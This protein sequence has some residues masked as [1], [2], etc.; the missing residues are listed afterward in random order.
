MHVT[1]VVVSHDGGNYLPRTLAA[2]SD[3]MRSADA[4]IGVDTGSTDNSLDLLREALGQSNVTTFHQAKSG[5][6][7]AVRAGL[8][9]LAPSGS[10]DGDGQGQAVEWI[11]LLHD[12]AAPAPDAL[13]ELLHAVERAPSVTVAGCKQL[14]WDNERHLVDA[15]LSTSRWAERL[16]LIDADEVD[17]GQYDARSDTFAVNSAGML[18]RRDVWEQLDGFDPAL[19]GSGDD[20]DFCWRNWLAGNRVVVVPTARMFHVEHRP[21]GLGT[22]S[23]ARKAQIHLRL[24]HTPWW[25]VPFQALGAL[26]GAIVRL[27]LSIL[28]KEPGYG[29]S[30]F[31]ATL[32]A[33]VRPLAVARGRR[34]AARTRRV[35]RSVVR[36]LQTPTREVRA[37][38]RSLLE[39]I[40][41]ADDPQP[42]SDL[43]APEPS[44]DA[45]DDFAALATNERGWVGTGAV[46]AACVALAAALIG[47]LGLLRSGVVTGGGLLPLPASP[48]EI[49]ASASSWWISLGAGL[50]GHGDPFAYVLWLI[51]LFGGGDG[52]AA[53]SWLLIL[54]M[55]LSAVGAWFA[56]GA[57][58]TKRRFRT[59]AALAWA[60]A[61]TLL[62]SINEGRV[63]AL[64]AHVMMPLLL[65]ALVR[66]SGSAISQPTS[67]QIKA[68]QAT[69]GRNRASGASRLPAPFRGKPGINGTPSWTA[70]AAAGLAMAVVTASAPSLLGPIIVA[71]VLAAVI[72]GQRGKTMWWS[73]LPTLALFLPYGISVLERPRSL[74]ADPGVPLGF[75]AAPLWQQLLGQPLAFGIDGGLTGLSLFGSGPVPWALILAL[76]IGVPVLLLAV[77]SLFLRGHR[78]ALARVFWLA[79]LATLASAWLVGH[80]ATGV[81]NNVIVGPFTGPA[82]S[83]SGMLL[84]GAALLGA[85]KIFAPSRRASDPARRKL[86]L[87]R[88]ASAVVV[89]L[90]VAGP[91]AGMGVWA[92]Q[93][94]LQPSTSTGSP[95]APSAEQ[96]QNSSLG[97]HR[98]IGPMD[99]GTLP[100]TAVDRGQGPERTRTLVIT[101]GEQGAFTSSL[102]RGAG[103]TLDSLS[104]IASARNI[105]GAPG[106]EE[107]ANDDAA[108]ASLRRAVAT[109][110]ASTGVDPRPDLEQLGAGFV[111]LKAADNAAQL[112]ASRIDAVPGLVAVGQTDAGWLWRVTPRDQPAASAA[113]TAHRVR[114]I[115]GQGATVGTLPSDDV[116][117]N[118]TVPSGDEGRKVVMAERSDPGWT[119]WV[120]GKQLKATTS[121]WSQAFDLPADGGELEIRYA[122]PWAVW[123]GIL[124]VVVISLTVLLAIPMPARRSRTGMS[125]DEV[126][127]RKEY[128]SV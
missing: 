38:R 64:V 123:L 32:A 92:A 62:I 69:T 35:H 27:V 79:A 24:K 1:A 23:A 6:G 41:P 50:P 91:L 34:A 8:H 59:V 2:L 121:G 30:Q 112:T 46:A 86:P 114:I 52:N 57:L 26:F 4:A 118:T 115:N 49:W 33:L 107:I 97:A 122:N 55:P 113:E 7:A 53:M 90:L 116:E 103:T 82:V 127:L 20:V 10:A 126:S 84:L 76:L 77:A 5:F 100:A 117:V 94:V 25:N 83:A 96:Q 19:P 66:A 43:L 104:T 14:G 81:N 61:P 68:S 101:S 29:F 99:A 63:G 102:M 85:E 39:A 75:D 108:T 58:T 48:G 105:I 54:A 73:L 65:L 67:A 40:R 11:W 51:S 93:N 87:R 128:S 47:L 88:I 42:V 22:S 111:V 9:E 18:I 119:A 45:A 44:G 109:I 74:L 60:G 17:Q 28:V 56:S 106:R 37:N 36:G 13:A 124:Q 78:T 71:V 31:T 3:Q 89:T 110:V 70:A 21:N 12:D 16:T 98:Q 125:R 120:D 15:G 95:A 72:L 80:V